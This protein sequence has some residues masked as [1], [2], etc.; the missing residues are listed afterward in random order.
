VSAPAVPPSPAGSTPPAGATATVTVGRS[1][2]DDTL[3]ATARVAYPPLPGDTAVDVAVV[4]AGFTGLWTAY[5][6]AVADPMLRIV[7]VERETVGRGASGRNGGWCS[8]L[9]PTSPAGL[10]AAY[11]RDT[12]A[13][14]VRAMHDTVDDVGLAAAAEGIDC[15]YA[16]GG[17][18][19]LARSVP[20]LERGRAELHALSALGFGEDD[21]RWL[22]AATARERCA[23][24]NLRGAVFTPHCAALHPG[25]LV[26]GLAAAVVRR[27]VV[28][29]EHTTVTSFAAGRVETTRGVVRADVVVRGTEAW[30]ATF[31]ASHRDVIP[32]YSMMIA[33]EPL[34]EST[35]AKIGLHDRS[36]FADGRHQIIYGQRTADHRFAFGGRGA[37]YHFGSTIR[38]E[39]DTD[40]R[41][42]G[43]LTR[44]LRQLFPTVLDAAITHHWGGPLGVPRDWRCSVR[45]DRATGMASAGGYVGDGVGTAH[46]AG[47]ILADLV[48]GTASDVVDLPIVGHASRRWEREPLRWLGVR[49]VGRAAALADRAEAR[50][51]SESRLWGT[52]VQVL[53]RR[54]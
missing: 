43:L 31:A 39:F 2:W 52:V 20:Q 10:A 34:P 29:H 15:D 54:S 18:L 38:P 25:K 41:V 3:P 6:L 14:M 47:R 30:T 7:V 53:T 40:D 19:D 17:T 5:H 27:G 8:A 51:G 33:T 48:T 4:G 23:A 24:T 13:R 16:K 37:P 50:T 32:L 49:T 12:A 22:D 11:G 21:Y 9:L 42:R 28:I 46:L 35:W 36:T 44:S 26:H 1:L 45:F